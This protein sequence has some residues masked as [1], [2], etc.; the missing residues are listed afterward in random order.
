MSYFFDFIV[1]LADFSFLLRVTLDLFQNGLP[2][3]L[4]W[5]CV[6]FNHPY[7]WATWTD[8]AHQQHEEYIQLSN[9]LK[10]NKV[11]GGTHKQW[12]NALTH[13]Q[14][15]NAMDLSRTQ[16][17]ATMTKDKKTKWI[18]EGK[19]FQC[20]QKGHISH[21][22]PQRNN[23]ITEASTSSLPPNNAVIA[24]ATISSNKALTAD[25]KAEIFLTQLYNESND[26]HAHFANIMFNK[27]EDFPHAWCPWLGLRH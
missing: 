25:Q 14:D 17:Q 27:K 22:C 5:N 23:Q 9:R 18:K 19:C 11:M 4:I 2:N 26:V 6:K 20:D 3:N 7:N 16:A 12:T 21:Y 1:T 15:P 24:I 8:S 13:W 10:G